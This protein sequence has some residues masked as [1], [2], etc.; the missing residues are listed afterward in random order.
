[1]LY[2]ERS[3]ERLR[4]RSLPGRNAAAKLF[5]PVGDGHNAAAAVN[6]GNLLHQEVLAIGRDVPRGPHRHLEKL[7]RNACFETR[8][9][10]GIDG[11]EGL[12]RASPVK[13][14]A[15]VARPARGESAA[16]G[17]ADFFARAGEWLHVNFLSARFIGYV[18][19]P[20]AVG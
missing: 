19:E 14:F 16:G 3:C 4:S 1:M 5:E 8:S 15:S 10:L 17:D 7:A 6:T 9:G 2:L 13:E 20:A 12:A 18:C 11:E